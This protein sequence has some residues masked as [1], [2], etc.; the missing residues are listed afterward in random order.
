MPRREDFALRTIREAD[1][2]I[3]LAWRNSERIR[4][5]SYTDHIIS[6]EEH[7][8]WFRRVSS[9]NTSQHFIFEKSSQPIGVVHITDI[10]HVNSKC[11]WGFYIG[12]S[13]APKG[14]GSIMGFM[15]LEYLVETLDIRKVT[16]EAFAF[17][18]DSL[19][20]HQRLGFVEEGRLVGH[21]L[22]AGRCEDVV[23]MALLRDEWFRIKP[24]LERRLFRPAEAACPE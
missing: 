15:A 20:F 8:N 2:E 1:L 24:E 4:N 22:K 7:R 23:V 17:N 9:G 11:C 21:V 3:V 14:S 18:T 6:L 13:E 12:A 10:D 5:V 19:R 16:G